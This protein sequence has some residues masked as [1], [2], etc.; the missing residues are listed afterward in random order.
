[1]YNKTMKGNCEIY[2]LHEEFI[3]SFQKDK[4]NGEAYRELFNVTIP[5]YGGQQYDMTKVPGISFRK[6]LESFYKKEREAYAFHKKDFT[7]LK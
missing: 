7:H 4:I 6:D 2:H 1:M 3:D 5:L